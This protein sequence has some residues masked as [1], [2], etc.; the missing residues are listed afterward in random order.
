MPVAEIVRRLSDL[1]IRRTYGRMPGKHMAVCQVKIREYVRQTYGC[2][3]GSVLK[4]IFNV[5]QKDMKI[6]YRLI[7]GLIFV[8]IGM[9]VT[10][11]NRG[12]DPDKP[13]E[14]EG[15]LS[16]TIGE[17]PSDVRAVCR[18][19]SA[20]GNQSV[21]QKEV[22]GTLEEWLPAGRY[23][24]AVTG[25]DPSEA[26]LSGDDSFAAAKLS[27]RK[28]GDGACLLS[29]EH[30]VYLAVASGL[31]VEKG[32]T[33]T[34][35]LAPSDMRHIL[36]L[37][38]DAGAGF[39]NATVD[40][41]LSG[42][43]ASVYITDGRAVEGESGLLAFTMQAAA[44]PGRYTS[45]AGV[46][47]VLPGEGKKE[48]NKLSFTFTTS[49]GEQF[50]YEEDITEQLSE[51]AAT[52][53]DTL[54]V[55]LSVSPA[56]PI[57]LYTGILT[58][59]SIDVFDGTAVSIAAGEKE[60]QYTENWDGTATGGEILLKPE[61]YYPQD[62]SAVYLRGYYPAAPLTGGEVHY[63]LTGQE[64]LMLSVPQS[65]SLASRFDPKGTPLTYKHLLAQLNF[66]LN[67]KGA[68][69]NYKV[70]SV[71]LNGMAASAVVSLSEGTVKPVSQSAPVVIYTDPGTGGFPI[72][73]G[74]VSLPGYVL[75]QPDATLTL[76]LVLAVDNNPANDLKFPGLPV[77]FEGSGTQG[78]NAYE[79]EI[80]FE[81]P[82]QPD[83][84]E[85]PGPDDPDDPDIP[86]D[87][88]D[89][90]DKYKITVTATV[91]EWRAGE[92]GGA[93]LKPV[94]PK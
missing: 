74:K 45:M 78:G 18:I 21:R 22:E 66:T 85:P 6:R 3:S 67:L 82:V 63:Q 65:G 79:V 31:N 44:I 16:L 34:H 12:D 81:I 29:L 77:H 41:T 94:Q 38:V 40:A 11:C 55:S 49:A 58:R 83:P 36:R 2:M 68:D 23:D 62:G 46:L 28:A 69:D 87:P 59:T 80:S 76:D 70:R 14:D 5:L 91:T 56:V 7:I 57:H 26:E 92:N 54:D 17:M 19:Y 51:A 86:V 43:A 42:I 30:P 10:G 27:A 90:L 71:Y 37:S 4:V 50:K 13:H 8:G 84:P 88:V 39:T 52:G 24:V 64:D 9:L 72:V 89:P 47:G 25:F 1:Y 48:V 35:S 32:K 33:C 61:R 73:D 93:I 20:D 60:G 75:V 15:L 53:R